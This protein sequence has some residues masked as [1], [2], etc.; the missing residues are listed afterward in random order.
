[1]PSTPQYEYSL[2]VCEMG[3]RRASRS[4]VHSPTP[5]AERQISLVDLHSINVCECAFASHQERKR[6]H[7]GTVAID[8]HG[9]FHHDSTALTTRASG[10][11]WT[12]AG[13]PH[14]HGVHRNLRTNPVDPSSPLQKLTHTV[15]N[16]FHRCLFL[17]SSMRVGLY[18]SR[19][20]NKSERLSPVD[21]GIS[22]GVI[23]LCPSRGHT[24]P[25]T[26][27]INV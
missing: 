19:A 25:V 13:L 3:A 20:Q 5:N 6:D 7:F 1:M 16:I 27:V 4:S 26:R 21:P 8:V 12:S 15:I 17:S 23:D 24:H 10:L 11:G 14:I 2:A 22:R 9:M 18:S